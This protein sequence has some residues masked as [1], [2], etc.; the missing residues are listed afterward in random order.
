MHRFCTSD[1]TSG[2]DRVLRFI[3]YGFAIVAACTVFSDS[4]ARGEDAY[5]QYVRTAP[6]YQRVSQDPE[7]MIGR[8]NTW[9]YMPWRYRWTIGTGAAGAKFCE[10]YGVNGGFT[11]HGEGPFDWLN[12]ANLRFYNDHTAGKGGLY[13]QN[14]NQVGSFKPYQRDARAIR[15]GA[16]PRPLDAEMKTRLSQ[17]ITQRVAH[18]RKQSELCVAY[19]LDDEVSWGAFVLPL[20]WRVNDDDQAYTQWLQRYY[21]AKTAPG[22]QYVTPDF[23]RPQFDQ[24]LG[25]L[26]FSALLDRLSYND[27]VWVNLLG[28]LVEVSNRADPQ[29]PCGIV[30]GQSP[31]IWGGYDY[32]K[33]MKKVQFI[34]AYDLG[35][36]QAIIRSLSPSNALPQV[37]THF[38]SNER[39][40]ANDVWQAWYYFAHG[41]RGMIGWVDGW[42][43]GDKPQPWL[44]QFAPALKEIG[45]RQAPKLV[46]SR[47]RHDGV[48]IYYSHPSVQV[49]WCLDIEPHGGTWVNRNNDFKLGTSH[50][51]R[52]AWEYLLTDSGIQYDFLGYDDV[53]VD[54]VPDDYRVLILP[55]CYALSDREAEQIT[56]FCEQGGTVVADF[57]CGL[58]DQHGKGRSAGALDKLFGVKHDGSETARDFF[59][60][61]LWVETDQDKAY[62][63]SKYR[64]LFDSLPCELR[65]G[66]ALA[67]GKLPTHQIQQI[68]KGRAVYINLS[69]QRYL[70]YR[71]ENLTTAAQ[72]DVFV[73]HVRDA[74]IEPWITVTGPD[75]RR[76]RNCETVYW[77]KAGR[78]YVFV[79]QNAAV[80]GSSLG[81]GG[82]KELAAEK[83][84]I[85]V[86]LLGPVTDVRNERTEEAL[87]AGSRFVLDYNPIEA[88]LFSFAGEPPT[89][90]AK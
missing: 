78:T 15:G 11:D 2:R 64:E 68:G 25:K 24:P 23:L 82:A 71:E 42:F 34:E 76:P 9:L 87:G 43:E 5:L 54:G 72:R 89:S 50:N 19:A 59:A 28:N 57:A 61:R 53:I 36:S 17:L 1:R 74:G 52:K 66:F 33:L 37:T 55:A 62:S 79:V 46:G 60:E 8:W 38:H 35:S 41:N 31:N 21:G 12:G 27:S 45:G 67:E 75:G 14:A 13:L 32:A 10:Q 44:E 83:I 84:R 80:T 26:D 51:V 49:S 3:V 16:D 29:T 81:G 39:G 30:G 90:A 40:D 65:E 86:R 63:Y 22:P 4:I 20:P 48:A 56:Q 73:R 47:W 77:T 58:F 85:D 18:V 6:E 70:Q 88:A 69:P 7:M